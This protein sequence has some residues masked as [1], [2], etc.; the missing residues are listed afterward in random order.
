MFFSRPNAAPLTEE[1]WHTSAVRL[2]PEVKFLYGDES[3]PNAAFIEDRL[4]GVR[5]PATLWQVA[6]AEKLDGRFT[7]QAIRNVIEGSNQLN[8]V[9]VDEFFDW[10]RSHHLLEP[11]AAAPKRKSDHRRR[12]RTSRPDKKRQPKPPKTAAPSFD[13]ESWLFGQTPNF[14]VSSTVIVLLTLLIWTRL[15][16]LPDRAPAP[17]ALEVPSRES[18]FLPGTIVTANT[19]G[20]LTDLLVSDGDAVRKG[21]V[22]ARIQDPSDLNRIEDLRREIGESRIRRDHHYAKDAKMMWRGEIIHLSELT[23]KL[24]QHQAEMRTFEMTAPVTGVV[25]TA[26]SC[27]QVGSIIA[28]GAVLM[29]VVSD[30]P[31][32]PEILAKR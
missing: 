4:S 14:L 20:V 10:L 27:S 6:I 12:R 22:I 17:P 3:L 13:N 18:D 30:L 26:E 5:H 19:G 29:S 25:T 21:D 9:E 28:P 2:R 23:R 24:G 32:H 15:D 8:L 16:P 11:V 1:Q 31:E 7:W